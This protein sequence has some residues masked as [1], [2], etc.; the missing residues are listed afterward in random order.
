[1][2]DQ[3]QNLYDKMYMFDDPSD[4]RYG[5]FNQVAFANS[6]P[7]VPKKVLDNTF[8]VANM[9]NKSENNAT[10]STDRLIKQAKEGEKS[11][12]SL[13]ANNENQ[14]NDD[15]R[16]IADKMKNF[17]VTFPKVPAAPGRPA[18]SGGSNTTPDPAPAP[19]PENPTPQP[20]PPSE[21][22]FRNMVVD[23]QFTEDGT[24]S[25]ADPNLSGVPSILASAVDIIPDG[26]TTSET[27]TMKITVDVSGA[28]FSTVQQN[29]TEGYNQL[30]I[31]RITVKYE[32]VDTPS[33]NYFPEVFGSATGKGK[34]LPLEDI[35]PTSN[36]KKRVAIAKLV[37]IGIKGFKGQGLPAEEVFEKTFA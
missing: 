16:S 12:S 4:P 18:Q 33:P 11:T 29:A 36:E 17:K 3:T 10:L 30:R 28:K 35:V 6:I 14:T 22:S 13:A 5:E 9:Y 26:G 1:M 34:L 24:Y 8:K 15:K 31:E 25:I 2:V 21:V 27:A 20:Q 23:T 7:N 32:R 37:N 19:I